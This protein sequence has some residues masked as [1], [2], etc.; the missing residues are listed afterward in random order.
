MTRAM[1]RH[2][3]DGFSDSM[4]KLGED[5]SRIKDDL[6]ETAHDIAEAASSGVSMAKRQMTDGIKVAR[7]QGR[8]AVKSLA[9][10]I[11]EKPFTSVAIAAG[12]GIVLGILLSRRG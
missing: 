1:K 11:E 4:E 7:K 5:A 6:A 12:A 10:H 2:A 8:E 3:E 9:E